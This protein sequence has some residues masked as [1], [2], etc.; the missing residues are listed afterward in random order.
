[1]VWIA[2]WLNRLASYRIAKLCKIWGFCET[3]KV[4][5]QDHFLLIR[6]TELAGVKQDL[7]S[8]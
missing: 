4:K 2:L 8:P 1:M 5:L 6:C 3:E 7:H